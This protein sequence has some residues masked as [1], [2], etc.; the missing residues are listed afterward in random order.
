MIRL[1]KMMLLAGKPR[2]PIIWSV[3]IASGLGACSWAPEWADP[4]EWEWTNP[5]EWY[6]ETA[7]LFEDEGVMPGETPS[8]MLVEMPGEPPSETLGAAVGELEQPPPPLEPIPGEAEPFPTLASVPESPPAVTSG[9]DVEQILSGLISD[10]EQARYTDEIL[11]VEIPVEPA[12]PAPAQPESF[13]LAPEPIASA[14]PEILYLAPELPG[15]TYTAV[16]E[17][18]VASLT[19]QGAGGILTIEAFKAVFNQQFEASGVRRYVAP[20]ETGAFL[21]PEA[22]LSMGEAGGGLPSGPGISFQAAVVHFENGQAWLSKEDRA[23]LHEVAD[24]QREKG[25]N[26]RVVGHASMRTRDMDIT[27]HKLVNFQLSVDRAQAV[28]DELMRLGVPAKALFV[29]A[30]SDSQPLTYEYMPAGET[31]NRRAEIFIEY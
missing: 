27:Q 29:S 7:S 6:D 30:A 11:R 9:E 13:Y 26:V 23:L 10:R 28:A 8:E 19:P 3:V 5:L 16:P 25:G 21:D 1:G 4:S 15:L 20:A 14:E 31:E 18:Q 24:L 2:W 12:A 22:S 17:Y